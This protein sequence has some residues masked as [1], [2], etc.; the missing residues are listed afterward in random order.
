[1][2]NTAYKYAITKG[3]ESGY[4][5]NIVASILGVYDTYDEARE[6][7]PAGWVADPDADADQG[8]ELYYAPGTTEDEMDGYGNLVSIVRIEDGY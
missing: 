2:V 7:I 1:M 8:G 6:Q 3:P 5:D 4:Y